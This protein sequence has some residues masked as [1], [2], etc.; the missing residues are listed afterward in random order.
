MRNPYIQ[1]KSQTNQATKSTEV[2]E[3]SP[4]ELEEFSS[5]VEITHEVTLSEI[6]SKQ[7]LPDTISTKL[8][9]TTRHYF[10]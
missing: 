9:H 3:G 7:T 10:N 8:D 1:E 4:L 5:N 6:L 2:I